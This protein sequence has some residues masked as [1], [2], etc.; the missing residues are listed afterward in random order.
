VIAFAQHINLNERRGKGKAMARTRY[1]TK[2]VND[3]H[4]I[5]DESLK[6]IRI[7]I[8]KRTERSCV[9]THANPKSR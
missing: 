3:Y 5:N 6:W 2:R 7:A 1:R 9:V 4:R 8:S